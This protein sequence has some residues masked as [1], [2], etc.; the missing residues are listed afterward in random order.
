MGASPEGYALMAVVLIIVAI[1]L[2]TGELRKD[3]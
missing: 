3:D 1:Q 2:F